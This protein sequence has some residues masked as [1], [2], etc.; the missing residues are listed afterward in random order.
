M[1]KMYTTVIKFHSLLKFVPFL[2]K[3]DRITKKSF[4]ADFEM[5]TGRN[6]DKKCVRPSDPAPSHEIFCSKTFKKGLNRGW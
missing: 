3:T 1:R 2:S 6:L 4:F 5:F